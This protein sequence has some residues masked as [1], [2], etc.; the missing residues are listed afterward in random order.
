[1][2]VEGIVETYG[3]QLYDLWLRVREAGDVGVIIH[4]RG[5]ASLGVL[6]PAAALTLARSYREDAPILA[7]AA[8][9]EL[10]TYVI[11]DGRVVTERLS[12]EWSN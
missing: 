6:H 2:S 12:A 3:P 1:M 4:A 9:G 7:A 11:V 5:R 8:P 10:A